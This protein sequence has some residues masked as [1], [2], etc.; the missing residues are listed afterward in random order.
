MPPSVQNSAHRCSP[1]R[2]NPAIS[3]PIKSLCDPKASDCPLR[4]SEI[5]RSQGWFPFWY[6]QYPSEP[7][8]N[9]RAY[10][11][12]VE[13]LPETEHGLQDVVGEQLLV[14]V[15]NVQHQ[16]TAASQHTCSDG[17]DRRRATDESKG[18]SGRHVADHADPGAGEVQTGEAGRRLSV[19]S[20]C[21][22]RSNQTDA[23]F[24]VERGDADPGSGQREQRVGGRR[25]HVPDP[26]DFAN[27]LHFRNQV[28][29]PRAAERRRV[30]LEA[31]QRVAAEADDRAVALR[32]RSRRHSTH[33]QQDSDDTAHGLIPFAVRT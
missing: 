4:E 25:Q 23:T 6:L 26:P 2:S 21:A 11:V 15:P 24:A 12:R 27:D 29:G 22:G 31:I 9:P 28:V 18:K 14:A 30:R 10:F 32:E 7:D 17:C 19:G 20:E 33:E 13:R 5:A 1:S 16:W 3:L 8:A